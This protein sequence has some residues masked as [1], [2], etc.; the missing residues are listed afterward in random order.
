M[1]H[2]ADARVARDAARKAALYGPRNTAGPCA[3]TYGR[4][5]A[6]DRDDVRAYNA[7]IAAVRAAMKGTQYEGANPEFI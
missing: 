5:C 6:A 3:D 7:A 1:T 4:W 2:L